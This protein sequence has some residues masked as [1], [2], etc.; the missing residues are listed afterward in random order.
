MSIDAVDRKLLNLIQDE[1]PME[2]EPYKKLAENL[3]ITEGQIMSRLD[4]LIKIGIVRRVGAI[5]DSR[6]LGYTG[7]LCALRVAPHQIEKVAEIING[8][9]GVTHNYLREHRYNMWFTLLAAYK[10]EMERILSEITAKT[11]INDIISLPSKRLFK[12]KVNF[13]IEEGETIESG[14]N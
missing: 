4:R 8:Y 11:G 3:G 12:I 1:F 13:K 5:F 7:T 6:K 10:N 9:N 14:R 2:S